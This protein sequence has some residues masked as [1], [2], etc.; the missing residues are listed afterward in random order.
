MAR[1]TKTP[2]WLSIAR[3]MWTYLGNTTLASI[4]GAELINEHQMIVVG[5]IFNA[6]GF[7]IQVMCDT[8]F[9]ADKQQDIYKQ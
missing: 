8:Y 6:V 3:K 5:I 9:I 2:Q 4:Y 7:F 1:K